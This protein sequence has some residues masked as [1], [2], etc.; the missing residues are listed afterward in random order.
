MPNDLFLGRG[1]G[2]GGLLGRAPFGVATLRG[3]PSA[4]CFAPLRALQAAHAE[5]IILY[6]IF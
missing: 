3:S 1:R 5:L 2:Y 6:K 4:P